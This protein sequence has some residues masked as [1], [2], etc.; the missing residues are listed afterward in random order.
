MARLP[1][2]RYL[3][4]QHGGVVSLFDELTDAVLVTFDPS[5]QDEVARAQ[6]QIYDLSVLTD[7]QK[8]FAYFWSGYFYAHAM[9]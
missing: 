9:G 5:D 2:E 3:I 4:Q 8:C 7:E 1:G 6:K